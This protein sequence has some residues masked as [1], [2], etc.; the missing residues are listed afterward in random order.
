MRST[1]RVL[2]GVAALSAAAGLATATFAQEP[3]PGAP[4]AAP[5]AGHPE[6]AAKMREHMHQRA[7]ARAKALHDILNITPDQEAAFQTFIASIKPPEGRGPMDGH[8]DRGE[9]SALTTPERLDKVAARIAERQA[10]FQRRADAIRHFY[11]ALSPAQQRAFDA[12]HGL[13]G[14]HHGHGGGHGWGGEGHMGQPP[15]EQ[16]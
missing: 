14:G 11:A 3:P 4:P 2:A 8:H 15:H 16:G 5:L 1:F 10:A 9:M 7:E 6:W 13:M 12:M